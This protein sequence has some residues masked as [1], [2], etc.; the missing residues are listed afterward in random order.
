MKKTNHGILFTILILMALLCGCGNQST[1]DVSS[2]S[3]LS[4]TAT[5]E[6]ETASAASE[7]VDTEESIGDTEG[8][9]MLVI[10]VNGSVFEAEW[11]D[12]AATAALIEIL[13][14][15][16]L[17]LQLDEYS[18]FEKVGSLGQSLPTDNR[19]MTTK[20]GDIVL[21]GGNNIVLFYGSNSWSYT[22]L[23]EVTDLTGW[24][25]ALGS[26][27]VSVTLSLKN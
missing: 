8:D 15:G 9:Q 12:N 27:S 21:Y 2:D 25:E 18:G 7:V 10:E 19:Q 5:Q 1:D 22:K 17:T 4:E 26:G 14:D 11:E 16:S 13:R 23:A 24:Q 3:I 20:S 6:T